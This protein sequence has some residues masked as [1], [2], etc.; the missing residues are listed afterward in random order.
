MNDLT[1][2][3]PL[4]NIELRV[5]HHLCRLAYHL[6]SVFTL[7]HQGQITDINPF[8]EYLLNWVAL[9]IAIEIIRILILILIKP[10]GS[11]NRILIHTHFSHRDI[12][13]VGLYCFLFG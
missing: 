5:I 9:Q 4:R 2:L 8:P 11:N 3:L 1:T 10:S 7:W 13:A 6:V 12:S